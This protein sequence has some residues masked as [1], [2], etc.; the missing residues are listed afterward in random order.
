MICPASPCPATYPSNFP[1]PLAGA[2]VPQ[3]SFYIPFGAP[4]ANPTL[5]NTWTWFSEG[6]SNYNALQLDVNRRFSHGLSLRGVYTWSKALDNGDSLNATTAQG[7]AALVSNPFNLKADYGLATY[8]VRQIAVINAVYKLPFGRGQAFGEWHS[9]LER[10][11]G[12]RMVG[13]QHRNRY[14][15]DSPLRRS[16]ATT[17]QTTETRAIQCVRS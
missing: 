16:S 10:Q 9:R 4:K 14:S 8:D 6:N 17:H 12:E 1:A 7:M 11:A 15:R 5:A 3:G 13:E 2:P